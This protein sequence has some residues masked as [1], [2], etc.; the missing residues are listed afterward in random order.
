MQLRKPRVTVLLAAAIAAITLGAGGQPV[1]ARESGQGPEDDVFGVPLDEY[2][3]EFPDATQLP[4]GSYLLAPG[5]RLVPPVEEARAGIAAA[6]PYRCFEGDVCLWQHS[7]F[8]GWIVNLFTCGTHILGGNAEAVSSMFNAWYWRQAIFID[9]DPA[10]DVYG[11]LDAGH[12]L[13]NLRWDT[14]PDGGNW[15]DR[16]DEVRIPC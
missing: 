15:N 5:Q 9:T 13:R 10:N 14:A 7:D 12:Y 8:S 16:I 1:D 6:P 11:Y 2:L 3:A 4:D